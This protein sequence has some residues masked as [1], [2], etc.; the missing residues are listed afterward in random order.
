MASSMIYVEFV[1]CYE[2]M[3][4]AMWLKKF[5]TGLRVIDNIKRSLKLYCDNEQ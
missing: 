5:V 3:G 2:G 4:P 1:A